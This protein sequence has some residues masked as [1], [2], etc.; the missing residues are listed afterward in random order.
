MRYRAPNNAWDEQFEI[1]YEQNLKDIEKDIIS[2]EDVANVAKEVSDSALAVANQ[3]N[4][5]SEQAVTK[6]NSVQEQFN[7]AV[8]E[9]DSSVEAAQA[10]VDENGNVFDTL[11][12][13]L[14]NKGHKI[15]EN[16]NLINSRFLERLIAGL[17]TKIKLIGDSITAGVGAA[18]YYTDPNGRPIITRNGSLV[19]ELGKDW[20]VFPSWAN[21]FRKY[22]NTN[23]PAIDFFNMGVGG[24]ST[25]EVVEQFLTELVSDDEDVV[26]V[27]LGTN[28]RSLTSLEE[29]RANIEFLLDYVNKRSNLMI[30]MTASPSLS[31]FSDET[32]TTYAAG[33]NFGA[34]EIDKV[35]TEVCKENGY[36]HISHYRY[37]LD[38]AS[39][40]KVNIPD[41]LEPTGSH[42]KSG[43][44]LAMW[45]NIQQRL[46]FAN[47]VNEWLRYS[48]QKLTI[49]DSAKIMPSCPVDQF[50]IDVS[51][52]L[53]KATDA[54][55]AG[56]P[57]NAGG[58]LKTVKTRET[59]DGYVYQTYT[60]YRT[61]K[62]YSRAYNET[63]SAWSSWYA[64]GQITVP[65]LS[66][67]PD[68]FSYA[69]GVTYQ[70]LTNAN[71][72]SFSLPE[73]KGGL[74]VTTVP[75]SS[76]DG[77]AKQVYYIYD[78]NRVYTRSYLS[79][80]AWGAWVHIGSGIN[81]TSNSVLFTTA[82]TS[83]LPGVRSLECI[84]GS[85]ST[86]TSFPEGSA[87]MLETI[88]PRAGLEAWA[89]QIYHVQQSNAT[90]KR[91]WNTSSSTWSAFQ[92]T[93]AV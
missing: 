11:K 81:P 36:I 37:L 33:R 49:I 80:N 8:I 26:F 55:T 57:E 91:Y 35:L 30:V 59:I 83:F 4:S 16:L 45:Q 44:H 19:R 67:T 77:W 68:T 72:S 38:Y 76:L 56:F 58:V 75:R 50:P 24:I 82:L 25:K 51:Y 17:I 1:N 78:S 65:S 41:F 7:Q 60:I 6:A 71:G 74:L 39:K 79:T 34:R 15:S 18:G 2:A 52:S 10:R 29:Y 73:G 89:Y 62:I 42:P 64:A 70:Y 23:Y 13:H 90:Y 3:S 88:Y 84:T 27:M 12:A 22:I 53:I 86:I 20:T 5:K 54:T 87:G 63:T 21:L 28:D 61:G 66:Y 31:D 93:S 14:D 47:D 69:Q 43:G 85:N 48:E 32:Y 92:K 40:R 46:G 9:G